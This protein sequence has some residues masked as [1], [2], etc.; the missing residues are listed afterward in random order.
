MVDYWRDKYTGYDKPKIAY[1]WEGTYVNSNLLCVSLYENCT[2][3]GGIRADN[4]IAENGNKFDEECLHY[5]KSPLNMPS[6]TLSFFEG[7]L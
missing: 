1:A 4:N 6:Y 7:I 2:L 5:Q 3:L